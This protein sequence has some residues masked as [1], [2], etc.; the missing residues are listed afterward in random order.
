MKRNK[1]LVFV[2]IT[3]LFQYG[4]S[5]EKCLLP[6]GLPIEVLL[7]DNPES[8]QNSNLRKGTTTYDYVRESMKP[9]SERRKS[10][11]GT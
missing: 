7:K 3:S 2:I 10:V 9:E 11:I 6:L 1:I 5:Q 8:E 4:Y